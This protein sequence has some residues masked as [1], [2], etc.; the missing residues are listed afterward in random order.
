METSVLLSQIGLVCGFVGSIVLA[1]AGKVGVIMEDGRI[2]FEGLDDMA[3]A[4]KNRRIVVNSHWRNRYF[5]PVGW[6]FLAL[7]FLLQFIAGL[8]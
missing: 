7:A 4:E 1:F 2:R 5:T 6:L 8:S 3:P